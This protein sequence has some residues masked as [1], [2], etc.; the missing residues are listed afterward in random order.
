MRISAILSALCAVSAFA[1]DTTSPLTFTYLTFTGGSVSTATT[2]YGSETG[3]SSASPTAASH[4]WS[5]MSTHPTSYAVNPS[6]LT[7]PTFRSVSAAIADA[8]AAPGLQNATQF[9][10]EALGLIALL[11]KANSTNCQTCKTIMSSIAATMRVQQE[12][13]S[14]IANPF[15][16]ELEAFL[17]TPICIGLLK[18][19]STD[20]GGI[21]PA[22]NMQG[23]DGQ[24]LCAFMFGMC[25][26]PTPPQLDLN[27][28]FKGTKKPPPLSLIPSKKE[29]LKVLHF[30]DYVS[31][32][33]PS[34][35][36]FSLNHRGLLAL[37]RS[38]KLTRR[39]RDMSYEN[40]RPPAVTKA[41]AAIQTHANKE[42]QHLDMRY[43]VG[44]EAN[45][46]GA[47][48]CR[49]FP[50]TN[51]SAPIDLPASLFGNYQCDTPEALATSVFRAVPKVT[52]YEWNDFSFGIYTGDLV[53]H[54][55]WELT[56]PYV[57]AE[58]LESYQQFFNGM[59]G[60]TLYPTLG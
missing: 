58:E 60:V 29:P 40:K 36:S 20:I 10:A 49:V 11:K 28:L 16:A 59:G 27:E 22:M 12:A 1:E 33:V 54:D 56:E 55:L 3:I 9:G 13:L 43:V 37:Q 18:V 45:C 26:L 23:E 6:D 51:A 32:S 34:M 7:Y 48:C 17:P 8:P 2:T 41:T 42:Q 50:Y 39:M 46:G 52:G 21:F 15:C 35:H 19:A 53:S 30:S 38:R 31:Y 24:T 14:I 25:T 44:S 4:P 57:L 47:L 5:D